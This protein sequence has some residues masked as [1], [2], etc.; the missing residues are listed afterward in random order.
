LDLI[1]NVELDSYSKRASKSYSF[2]SSN[3]SS[4]DFIGKLNVVLFEA[5]DLGIIT[6]SPISRRRFLDIH[7]S[8]Q[9]FSY[10]KALQ[11]YN[12]VLQSRNKVLKDIK[13]RKSSKLELEFWTEKIIEDGLIISK[14]RKQKLNE[15]KNETLKIFPYFISNNE[16]LDINFVPS[17][18]DLDNLNNESLKA[19]FLENIKKEI[20]LGATLYGPHKDDFEINI[21][22]NPSSEF[23]SRGQ[24]R[25]ITLA[26]KLGEA[27]ALK[28]NI[29]SSP[30]I[31]L[32]DILSELDE[33][34][35]GTVM[36]YV[37]NY[38]QVLLTV[39]DEKLL[40]KNSKSMGKIFYVSNGEI[41]DSKFR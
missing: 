21:N 23:S 30:I 31:A 6:G 41:I 13:I 8:Q 16:N 15:I 28:N 7:I 40:V 27:N 20:S 1:L 19:K 37:S 25:T 14:Q 39:P 38:D 2:N 10:L 36:E 11:R 5:K 3:V 33:S 34:R 17:Y 24:I 9:D 35:R 12:K 4:L 32:D 29:N 26:L 22:N 18:D